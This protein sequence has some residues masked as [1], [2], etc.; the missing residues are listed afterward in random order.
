M[1]QPTVDIV[2]LNWNGWQETIQCLESI[3]Q[4]SYPSYRVIVVDNGST[5]ESQVKLS[6]FCNKRFDLLF[7]GENL[8]YAGGNNVGI[9]HALAQS[10]CDYVWI[11][12]NDTRV[13]PKALTSLVDTMKND[14]TTGLCGSTILY[15][16]DRHRVQAL[17]GGWYQPA[18]G[19][20]GFYGEGLARN[21]V[22]TNI[23][24]KQLD[25]I[26]GA[27]VLASKEFL[28]TV[29][30]MDEFLFLYMEEIDWGIRA[31]KQHFNLSY[32]KKSIVYHKQG[33]SIGTN[34]RAGKKTLF[35]DF[36]TFRNR[37]YLTRKHYWY[38]LPTVYLMMIYSLFKRIVQRRFTAALQIL[39]IMFGCK[40][41]P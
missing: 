1:K 4:L 40:Q 33:A 7:T 30:L 28:Q 38:F 15:E 21:K 20:S 14:P 12:N 10:D 31:K 5:D 19:L 16:D 22:D 9:R 39:S 35:S 17:G 3:F 18:T 25:L 32:A 23:R 41:K 36:Y 11:L 24:N 2:I 6:E 26:C 29:G 34:D 8:G 37:I 13:D 27:S